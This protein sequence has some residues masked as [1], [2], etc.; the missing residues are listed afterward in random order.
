[1]AIYGASYIGTATNRINFNDYSGTP[2]YRL[3]SRAPQRRALRELDIPIPFENGISDF[4]TLTGQY[5]YVLEG[6]MYPGGESEYDSGIA[7]LRK[8]ASLEISQ[9]DNASDMGYV[10]YVWDEYVADKQVNVKVLYVDI[11]E[12]T[13]KGLVQPFRFICKIK[14]PTVFSATA[15]TAST[16]SVD[17]STSSGSAVHAFAYPIVYGASTYSVTNNANNDGDLPTYPSSIVVNGPVNSPK[18]TNTTTG[19]YIELSTNLSTSANVL[20]ITY[21][22]DTLTAT[23]D[24]T[25]VLDTASANTIWFKLQ[26]GVNEIELTGSSIGSGAYVEINYRDAWPLA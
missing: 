10:P 6:I 2:I 22:K 7:A 13:R 11:R 24:G 17:P 20:T 5:A 16:E 15:K 3:V 26:P 8:L 4:E 25:S 14:D 12:D 9:D 21:D 23:V 1:M 18:I 19:E